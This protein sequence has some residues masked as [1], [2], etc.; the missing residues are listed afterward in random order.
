MLLVVLAMSSIK[1]IIEQVEEQKKVRKLNDYTPTT[2]E[3]EVLTRM[4]EATPSW[5]AI[6]VEGKDDT[7]HYM[8]DW[9]RCIV[10][11]WHGHDKR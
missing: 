2:E 7:S 9:N 4:S 5:Y 6:I 11:E 8:D 10:G 1:T 3:Q